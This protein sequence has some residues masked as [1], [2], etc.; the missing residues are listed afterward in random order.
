MNLQKRYGH[1]TVVDKKRIRMGNNYYVK[2]QCDC[3]SP[4]KY[5]LVH[6]MQ[7]GATTSC[8]CVRAKLAAER[9]NRRA[10]ERAEETNR[11]I[12]E[13]QRLRKLKHDISEILWN[14]YT[15]GK[16]TDAAAKEIDDI[17]KQIKARA[18]GI[19]DVKWQSLKDDHDDG[20]V[21]D[22]AYSR[23]TDESYE[24]C[25]KVHKGVD[26][27]AERLKSMLEK[28]TNHAERRGKKAM[29]RAN[30]ASEALFSRVQARSVLVALRKLNAN[31]GDEI[32]QQLFVPVQALQQT[33]QRWLA[34]HRRERAGRISQKAT[35]IVLPPT[36]VPVDSLVAANE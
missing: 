32:A 30:V 6:N 11:R 22:H 28:V 1:L 33:L 5:V 9:L 15:I 18:S 35:G 2:V 27:E 7:S 36:P 4:A 17:A 10:T 31:C 24:D 23:N 20:Y 29:L 14:T 19:W 8:G 26:E 25:E 16:I 13:K 3:G 12:E 21:S 34:S